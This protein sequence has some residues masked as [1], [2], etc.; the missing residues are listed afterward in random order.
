MYFC[1]YPFCMLLE[2]SRRVKTFCKYKP[3][4]D[5]TSPH[6][7]SSRPVRIRPQVYNVRLRKISSSTFLALLCPMSSLS[8]L[9]TYNVLKKK[10]ILFVHSLMHDAAFPGRIS[11][12][13]N[14][15]R[16]TVST[17][18]VSVMHQTLM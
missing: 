8:Y 11:L 1:F 12:S 5:V 3:N 18:N 17:Y 15:Q 9:K 16:S 4:Y 2:E 6:L 10:L 7:S 13:S 14:F